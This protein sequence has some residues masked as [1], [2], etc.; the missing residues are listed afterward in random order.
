[1]QHQTSNFSAISMHINGSVDVSKEYFQ[2]YAKV[3]FQKEQYK[4]IDLRYLLVEARE[5]A[6]WRGTKTSQIYYAVT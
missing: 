4:A 1:M 6:I 3:S 5:S 2:Q